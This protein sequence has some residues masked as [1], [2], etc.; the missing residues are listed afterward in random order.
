M[1]LILIINA[2]QHFQ[3]FKKKKKTNADLGISL[4]G[5]ADRVI[6]CD[7]KYK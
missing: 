5:D 1:V 7:E 4:D 6:M 2:D 3:T